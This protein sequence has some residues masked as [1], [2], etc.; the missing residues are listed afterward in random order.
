MFLFLAWFSLK[1]VETNSENM[2]VFG[3]IIKINKAE[4]EISENSDIYVGL[5]HK[6]QIFRKGE[7][8]DR[9]TISELSTIQKE[10]EDL[11]KRTQQLLIKPRY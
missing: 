4:L 1:L 2:E 3:M 5:S 8:L 11:I 7:E 6:G 9:R 10:A